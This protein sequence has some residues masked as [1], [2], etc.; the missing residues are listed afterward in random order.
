MMVPVNLL[1]MMITHDGTR[2]PI[3]SLKFFRTSF[4]ELLNNTW[5]RFLAKLQ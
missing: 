1:H 3:I 2:K 4:V 5:K